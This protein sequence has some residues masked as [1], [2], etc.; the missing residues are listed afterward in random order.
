ME[1]RPFKHQTRLQTPVQRD[2]AAQ[3]LSPIN[4]HELKYVDN[5]NII[6]PLGLCTNVALVM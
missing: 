6:K 3:L 5:L 1:R 4:I 2:L